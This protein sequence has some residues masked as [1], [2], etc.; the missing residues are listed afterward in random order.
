M[1]NFK[2]AADHMFYQPKKLLM[3]AADSNKVDAE[4]LVIGVNHNGEA[5]AYPIQ[6]I[7]YH[8]QVQDTV[9]GKPVI[10]T[11][12]T[13]C[14]TGY[15]NHCLKA[16]MKHSASWEWIISTPCLKTQERVAGGGR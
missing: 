16:G 15:L 6:F 3:V 10:V 5:R 8:H 7:G 1:T 12:C 14:R 4:R 2:M 11:Y 9:G 13:V